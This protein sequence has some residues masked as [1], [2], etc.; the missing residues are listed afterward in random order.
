MLDYPRAYYAQGAQRKVVATLV[1]DG[2]CVWDR[3]RSTACATLI[4]QPSMQDHV[5]PVES[6]PNEASNRISG[7]LSNG[8]LL[9]HDLA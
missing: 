8:E 1:H 9:R 6:E 2:N 3:V 5:K 4:G 7:P